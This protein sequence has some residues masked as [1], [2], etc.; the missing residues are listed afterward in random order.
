[1]QSCPSPA[2]QPRARLR[3]A[4]V[5]AGRR[6]HVLGPCGRRRR[7]TRTR[8]R[9]RGRSRSTR[10]R[11]RRRW[12]RAVRRSRSRPLRRGRRL[13]AR[14]TPASTPRARRRTRCRCRTASTRSRSAPWMRRATVTRRPRRGRSSPTRPLRRPGSSACARR[15]HATRRRFSFDSSSP[16]ATFECQVDDGAWATCTSPHTT[17]ALADGRHLFAVRAIHG[18]ADPTPAVHTFRIDTTA[19]ATAI[20][21][22]RD[23]STAGR[24][25]S[26]SR[27]MRPPRSSARSTRATSAR[28]RSRTGRRTSRSGSTSCAHAAPIKRGTS[29]PWSACLWS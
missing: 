20:T 16:D 24:S 23:R 18:P 22:R 7:G 8:R 25:R 14:S 3:A 11:R 5:V 27:R 10:R 15:S 26:G 21:R 19:P 13:N 6:A 28:A 1:M 12:R 9:S 2:S 29:R 17:A 4:D